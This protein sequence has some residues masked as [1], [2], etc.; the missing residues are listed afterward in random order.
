MKK[1][2]VICD[3]IYGGG[4]EK[5]V[6]T[7]LSGIA[8]DFD[9]T[10]FTLADQTER[11]GNLRGH[12]RYHY[13]YETVRE[14]DSFFKKFI[15]K[16]KNKFVIHNFGNLPAEKFY[17]KYIKEDFDI[18]L[19]ALEGEPV[20]IISGSTNKNSRKVAWVHTDLVAYP[21]TEKVFRSVFEETAAYKKFNAFICVSKEAAAAFS[22]KFGIN[23]DISTIYNPVDKD[24]IIQKSLCTAEPKLNKRPNANKPIEI[25]SIGRFT[26]Q[27]GFDVLLLVFKRL[28]NDGLNVNLSI[29]GDGEDRQL[30]E[31]IVCE[32]NIENNVSLPG[33][34]DNPF[35]ILKNSD[36]F[37]CSS[38]AEGFSLVLAEA[39]ILGIPV[40]S[41]KSAGP[42]ELLGN[43][44]F[45]V[46]TEN[47]E[48]ALYEG[49]KK[50]VSSESERKKYAALS[51]QRSEFFEKENAIKKIKEILR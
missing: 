47:C 27:K 16:L 5:V 26:K 34:C 39:M 1:L 21:W 42:T 46:L 33:F 20:K 23:Q 3:S 50:L 8:G 41:T 15:K 44:E 31:K 22:Q 36:I 12:L 10:L 38:R 19:A 7:L 4:A 43:G 13:F 9:I 40:V 24:E 48:D 11:L 28:L 45:G 37:V 49:L 25:I 32:N 2:L 17:K 51:K 14:N 6:T 29:I 18:E 30:L 35:P